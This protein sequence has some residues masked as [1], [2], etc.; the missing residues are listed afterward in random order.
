[1]RDSTSVL[2]LGIC[3]HMDR[4]WMRSAVAALA[5]PTAVEFIPSLHSGMTNQCSRDQGFD[6]R[7]LSCSGAAGQSIADDGLGFLQNVAQMIRAAE[8]L[9]IDLVYFLGP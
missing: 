9:R 2:T 8:A 6:A 4:S 3:V 1:M 5:A 7:S